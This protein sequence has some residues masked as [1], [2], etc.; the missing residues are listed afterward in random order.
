MSSNLPAKPA[1]KF[2]LTLAATALSAIV[3][4]PA[5]W[6]QSTSPQPGNS[7]SSGTGGTSGNSGLIQKTAPSTQNG[8]TAIVKPADKDATASTNKANAAKMPEDSREMMEDLAEANLAEIETGKLALTA[9]QNPQVKKFAQQMIADHTKAHNELKKIAQAK[10]VELPAE[11]DMAQKAKATTL[12]ALSGDTF[13]K[14]YI[15][16]AG[17]ND[18]QNTLELLQKV[19]KEGKDKELQAYASK[20][21]PVVQSHLKMAQN[22]EKQMK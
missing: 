22:L 10:K 18:H 19:Q 9:S 15:Q 4:A 16:H 20:T 2:S 8:N 6:A 14:Q 1:R 21:L 12:K 7:G 17:E 5:T 13:D 3:L 11:P